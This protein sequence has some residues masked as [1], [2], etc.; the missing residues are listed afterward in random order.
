M[1]R[2]ADV[3][4]LEARRFEAAR[5]F[6]RGESQA[7]VA[8]ALDVTPMTACRW[9]QA[10]TRDGR[11]GLKA[12]GRLGRKPRLDRQ[13]LAQVD[14]ALRRGPTAHGFATDL[15]TLPRIAEVIERQ[16]GLRFHPGHV[17]RILRNLNWSLQRPARQA[18]E[19]DEAAIRR[20]VQRRWPM[21]KKTPDASAPG[22]SSKTKA[23]SPSSR[24]SAGPGRRAAKPPF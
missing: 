18:V 12:A 16:T 6:A 9:F 7:A 4:A 1:A 23:A 21:V 3:A 13:Q 10:W 19:R 20:W 24:S 5:R 8:R 22:S 17:W 2:K 15:W 14:L 11:A